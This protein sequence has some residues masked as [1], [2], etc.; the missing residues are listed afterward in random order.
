MRPGSDLCHIIHIGTFKTGTTAL[1]NIVFPNAKDAIFLGQS[2]AHLEAWEEQD[3]DQLLGSDLSRLTAK[4]LEQ[5]HGGVLYRLSN[6]LRKPKRHGEQEFAAATAAVSRICKIWN[7][8]HR[9]NRFLFSKEGLLFTRGHV[10]PETASPMA[11]QPPLAGFKQLPGDKI[12][13]LFLRNPTNY[14]FSRYMQLQ[15]RRHKNE[16]PILSVSE[17]MDS[18]ER[19][20]ERNVWHSV[21]QHALQKSFVDAIRSLGFADL[22]VLSYERDLV[23]AP[24]ITQVLGRA[25]GLT[26]DD[27]AAVDAR[28]K[29][30][31]WNSASDDEEGRFGRGSAGENVGWFHRGTEGG[32]HRKCDTLA[33]LSGVRAATNHLIAGWKLAALLRRWI[34][35]APASAAS[36]G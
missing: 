9:Q 17:F 32:F 5:V 6:M 25:V 23:E 19:A 15:F 4:Q 35:N 12:I 29:T 24:S 20:Y 7:E 33:L 8:Q 36:P 10:E 11:D 16:L 14:L 18:Q 22:V 34:G 21:I 13:L 1:Q 27:A 3:L 2:K 30:E 28:M 31:Y 26:F